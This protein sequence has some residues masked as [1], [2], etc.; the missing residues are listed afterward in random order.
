MLKPPVRHTRGKAANGFT[1]SGK[2]LLRPMIE[3]RRVNKFY[4]QVC[5]L[6]ELSLNVPIG[7]TLAI[8]GPSGCGKTT[9]L[10]L[11]NR[12]IAPTSGHVLLAG[13]DISQQEPTQLRRGIGYVVQ[14]AGLLPHLNVQDN[15]EVVPT[16]LE[17]SPERRRGRTREL[18]DLVGLSVDVFAQRYPGQ[19]S[20]GQRQR[21]GIARALAAD[22]HVVLMDEPFGALDAITRQHLQ[23]EFVAIKDTLN[24]TIV[25]VTHDLQEA[26]VL[27]DQIAVLGHGKLEQ[28]GTP[29]ALRADPAPLTAELLGAAGLI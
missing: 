16:L 29:Q 6:R 26:F 14:D 8:V 19:L 5:V 25:I 18:L 1:S 20:G 7:S 17:W 13:E 24:K 28:M 23:R 2:D 9:A 12:L 22:P 4:G 15:V 21:V 10:K 11:I 27:A 3:F